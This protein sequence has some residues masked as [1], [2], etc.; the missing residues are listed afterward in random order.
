MFQLQQK[1]TYSRSYLVVMVVT[2][3]CYKWLEKLLLQ[4]KVNILQL[5]S[6]W[7]PN[8]LQMFQLQQ[9]VTYSRSYLIV[10]L[11]TSIRYK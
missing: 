8:G 1:V 10:T 2:S 4:Q 3:I 9:K 7:D 6:K 5:G 11:V